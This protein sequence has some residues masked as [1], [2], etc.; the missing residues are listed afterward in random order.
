MD[1]TTKHGVVKAQTLAEDER[2]AVARLAALCN[3]YEGLDFPLN[4]GHLSSPA[5]AVPA[6]S[7]NHLLYYDRGLLIGF[8]NLE[9]GPEIELYGMVHPEHRRKGVGRALFEAAKAECRQRGV[10]GLLLVCDE[11]SQSGKAFVAAVGAQYRFSEH[12]ME[13]D[14]TAVDRSRPRH[15][16]LQLRPADAEDAEVLARLQAASF[17]DPEEE[18]RQ[19]VAEGLQLPNR[20]Y[21][22]AILDGEPI[23]LLRAGRYAG[24]ADITAFGVLPEHRGR[25]YGRQM[26]L[27]VLDILAAENWQRIVIDVV[28]ENRNA[29]G[30]YRSVGFKETRTYGYYHVPV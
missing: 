17:G 18:V 2:A 19:R 21:F 9:H 22:I 1:R 12:A 4:W 24:F 20:Q 14:L 26:L 28:T 6:G 27:D 23:G 15:A 8:A 13:L 3:Q 7:A 11:A 10:Q 29:L 5:D 30:L 25:G 16:A